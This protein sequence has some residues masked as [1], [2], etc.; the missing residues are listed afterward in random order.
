MATATLVNTFGNGLF[1][2]SSVLFYTRTLHLSPHQVGVGLTLAGLV[3]LLVGVPAGHLADLRGAREVLAAVYVLEAAA[4]ACLPFVSGFSAF[5]AVVTVFTVIDRAGN[6]VRQ[7]LIAAAFPPQD[8]VAGRAYLRAVTN[9]GISFGSALAGVAIAVDSRAAYTALLLGD[10]VTYLVAAAVIRRLPVSTRRHR[11]DGESMLMALRDGPFVVVTLLTGAMA[12]QY[13]LLEVGVPLWVDRYTDA[14]R[15]TVALL[16]VVNTVACV[17]FQVRASRSAVDVASSARANLRGAVLIAASCVVF[18]MASGRSEI[19]AVLV[20]VVA[21]M[22]HVAGEL[23]Q[24]AGA[25]GLGFGLSPEHAQGQYQGLYMTGF[26]A[27]SMLGPLVITSTAISWGRPGWYLLGAGFLLIGLV[28]VP[29]SRWAAQ[30]RAAV[31][32]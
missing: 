22:V 2:T 29:V 30:S 21:A 26:A 20:L 16:F 15:W 17:L 7:G 23:F 4:M 27:A 14:P 6:A 8:R 31:T 32:V 13:V 19:A 18:A 10:A 3:A 25:W 1:F 9:L 5:L 11:A 24:A 28:L 12:M